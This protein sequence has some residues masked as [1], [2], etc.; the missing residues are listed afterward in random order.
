MERW[1]QIEG[2]EGYEVS[3]RGRVRSLDRI[4]DDMRWPKGWRRYPG[5]VLVPVRTSAGYLRVK[6]GG[7]LNAVPIHQLVA[8]AFIGKCPEGKQ[9]CHNDGNKNNNVVDN[10]R[11][12]FPKGNMA[13]RAK[14]GVWKPRNG[15][16][17]HNAKLTVKQVRKI[18][19]SKAPL[20]T[21]AARY[22]VRE[23]QI[24]RIRL[25]QRWRHLSP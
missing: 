11:Y 20:A 19:G 2:Y 13:D 18:R 10:L 3:D 7:G 9:V 22:G 14:H 24:S 21:L 17:H 15:E 6:L 5:R 4:I 23:A 12:D 1:K 25:G 16:R 8:G